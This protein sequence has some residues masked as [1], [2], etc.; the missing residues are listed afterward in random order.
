MQS[1]NESAEL[2]SLEKIRTDIAKLSAEI[3]ADSQ[4]DQR[5]T[6]LESIL[7]RVNDAIDRVYQM[8]SMESND[9]EDMHK[10]CADLQSALDAKN[11][12]VLAE[13]RAHGETKADLAKM[14]AMCEAEKRARAIAEDALAVANVTIKKLNETILALSK[15]EPGGQ[16]VGWQ[17]IP[18][19]DGADMAIRYE[20]VP[21]M[22]Q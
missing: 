13:V 22:N 18:V 17:V 21:A 5:Q 6:A 20:I 10:M 16:P 9:S 7:L 3:S 11:S 12:E 2:D 1:E 8:D 15:K 19:R 14:T 4:H